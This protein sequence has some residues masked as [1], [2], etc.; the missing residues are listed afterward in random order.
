MIERLVRHGSS[1]M[2][3]FETNDCFDTI[4]KLQA[5]DLNKT[6]DLH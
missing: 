2:A 1:L 5:K 3:M 4:K 6:L